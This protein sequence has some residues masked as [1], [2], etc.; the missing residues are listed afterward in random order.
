MKTKEIKEMTKK[1][2]YERLKWLLAVY[3]E[4]M[5]RDVLAGRSPHKSWVGQ[6][7][8]AYNLLRNID[9]MDGVTNIG[10]YGYIHVG[11]W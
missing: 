6:A 9:L 10:W 8:V 3:S 7:R 4:A 1:E 2:R 5:V 11:V